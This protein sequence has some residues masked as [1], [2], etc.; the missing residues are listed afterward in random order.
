MKDSQTPLDSAHLQRIVA[1]EDEDARQSA[2]ERIAA[3]WERYR[4]ILDESMHDPAV[5]RW[6]RSTLLPRLSWG[7][8]DELVSSMLQWPGD[9]SPTR[10]DHT[11]TQLV[12]SMSHRQV[13]THLYLLAGSNA[14]STVW[15]RIAEEGEDAVL[16]AARDVF[17]EANATARETTLHLLALDPYG[18][19]PLDRDGQDELLHLA[20]GD[21]DPE[22]RG[23][24]AEVIAADMP[25]QLLSQWE[26][27]PLD[28]SERVRM[29]FWYTAM[30][31][32][33]EDALE[34]AAGLVLD[35]ER[36]HTARR[37]ALIA[38]GEG[39][40]TRQMSPLLQSLLRGED[41]VLAWDAAQL[42]WRRHRAPDI[43][44][45]AAESR[46][47]RVRELAERLLHPERGSPAAGGSRPGDPTR[48]GDIF[49]QISGSEDWSGPEPEE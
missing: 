6:A 19:S 14:A 3:D 36:D 18:E 45:A 37:T 24:A 7:A 9:F 2:A 38:I 21:P 39:A 30:A 4:P 15:E 8:V 31:H 12:R 17:R 40:S 42:M 47:E 11:T 41:E 33:R 49:E 34:Y 10:R 44:G 25:D 46:F 20:L 22:V 13:R 48:T 23:L 26:R 43:A 1:S 5:R 28:A 32:R 16:A 29:A 27:A 35:P